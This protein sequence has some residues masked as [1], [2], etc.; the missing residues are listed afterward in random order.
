[1]ARKHV[2]DRLSVVSPEIRELLKSREY[3]ESLHAIGETRLSPRQLFS[4]F[5]EFEHFREECHRTGAHPNAPVELRKAQYEI[6]R[7]FGLA[8]LYQDYE[9]TPEYQNLL[10]DA[11]FLER[12]VSSFFDHSASTSNRVPLP[13]IRQIRPNNLLYEHTESRTVYWGFEN[14]DYVFSDVPK[15]GFTA[16]EVESAEFVGK[17]RNAFKYRSKVPIVHAEIRSMKDAPS[18]VDKYLRKGLSSFGEII[19][20]KGMIIVVDSFDK[21]RIRTLKALLE[22]EL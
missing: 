8:D 19:D 22:N 20:Q 4:V 9:Q 5:I 21:V 15:P 11:E 16:M 6:Q 2:T 3:F 10:I 18:A 7:L 1:M 17:L 12:K 13:S 14:G